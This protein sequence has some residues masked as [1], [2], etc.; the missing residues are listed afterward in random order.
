M[1]A[2]RDRRDV[3]LVDRSRKSTPVRR[4]PIT[5][6]HQLG[7]NAGNSI[8]HQYWDHLVAVAA[9]YAKIGVQGEDLSGRFELR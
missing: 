7:F 3:T 4:P 1:S 6:T 5:L 2:D 8:G 9:V